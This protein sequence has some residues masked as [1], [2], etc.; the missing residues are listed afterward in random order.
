M[1]HIRNSAHFN[2]HLL[3]ALKFAIL[4]IGQ[5]LK[6]GYSVSGLKPKGMSQIINHY[7]ILE[8]P[9]LNNPEIL[10]EEP[11]L[12]LHAIFAV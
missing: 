10:D 9:I 6:N 1:S 12:S 2:E 4:T 8:I 5:K 7:D 11:V 3:K